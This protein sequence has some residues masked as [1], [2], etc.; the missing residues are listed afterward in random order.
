VRCAASPLGD[1][2]LGVV[3][4]CNNAA[5]LPSLRFNMA[6]DRSADRASSERPGFVA[7]RGTTTTWRGWL[8]ALAVVA[9]CTAISELMLPYFNLADLI[10]VYLAGVVYVALRF[11]QAAAV[12]AVVASI[13][14]FD[15][16]FVPPRWGLN[17]HNVQHFFTFAVMLAVGL[18]ISRLAARAGLQAAVAN[19][20]ASRAQA[21]NE[22]A[23]QLTAARSEDAIVAGLTSAVRATFDAPCVVL[24]P[25]AHG[26]LS[27]PTGF[28]GV[29]DAQMHS[30]QRVFD[31]D[32]V[33][34]QEIAAP[35]ETRTL[36]LSLQGAGVSLGVLAIRPASPSSL[37]PEEGELLKAFANQAAL[38]LERSMFERK[39][40]AAI[41]EAETERLRSTLLSG[42]SHDFR[43]PLTTIV[44]SATSLL[45][46]DKVLDAARRTTLTESILGEAQRMHALVSDLLDLTRMEEGAVQPSCE[47]CPADEL[48]EE[49]RDAI[50]P[51]LRSHRLRVQMPPDAIVWC[52]P[53]LIE[54]VLVNLLDN[55]LRHTPSGST[56]DVLLEVD[57]AQWRLVVADDGPGLPAGQERDVFKKFFRGRDEPAGAG[58]GLGL[59]I[60]A[61]VARL[62]GGTIEVTNCSGARF[63]LTLPQALPQASPLEEAA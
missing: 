56:I 41:V 12:A 5:A 43:S 53:R 21:L 13:F 24:R 50:G 31:R 20:R 23:R 49:A 7:A 34:A 11:G 27:D 62:H 40:A 6:P 16:I 9:L 28:F 54:Q 57:D 1:C 38:A 15:L 42:I 44:G 51:R 14:L 25:D 8:G 39:S 61:A 3:G 58:T 17:P 26:K 60:C 55:A 19:A 63:T 46:Q 36:Y 22:L 2:T 33:A 35:A 18:L 48:V 59:A 32:P 4:E 45:Q 29:A 10:M 47:W 37:A 30:A 52:D